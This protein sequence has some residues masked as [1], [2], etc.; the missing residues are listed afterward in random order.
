MVW[1]QQKFTYIFIAVRLPF[2]SVLKAALVHQPMGKT[3]SE[4]LH[5][6]ADVFHMLLNACD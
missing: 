2:L 6:T 3:E 5:S 4:M 1:V